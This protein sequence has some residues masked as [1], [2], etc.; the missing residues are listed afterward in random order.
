MKLSK[1]FLAAGVCAA[2][3]GALGFWVT[4]T[5]GA[6]WWMKQGPSPQARAFWER[7]HA[8]NSAWLDPRPPAIAYE[9]VLQKMEH[10]YQR[11]VDFWVDSGVLKTWCTPEKNLRL[12]EKQNQAGTLG[13]TIEHRYFHGRGE[14]VRLKSSGR[15]RELGLDVWL[16]GRTGGGFLC[17]TH[18]LA[19]WGLL[20]QAAVHER[21]ERTLVL[22]LTNLMHLPRDWR[23]DLMV[24]PGYGLHPAVFATVTGVIPGGM[25][26]AVDRATLLPLYV[27]ETDDK[28]KTESKITFETPWL[29][30][31]GRKVPGVIR[32]E[33]PRLKQELRYEFAVE[34][35][36][37]LL[38]ELVH[39]HAGAP[40]LNHRSYT[41]NL[42]I[43]PVPDAFFPSPADLEIP[44][45]SFTTLSPGE[46]MVTVRTADGLLLEGKLSLPP[47]AT[48]PAPVVFFL[49]GAGPWTFDRPLVYPDFE[50]AGEFMPRMKTRNYCDW[51]ARELSAR[52][53]GFFRM[54]KR[55]CGIVRDDEGHPREIC[56]RSVFSKA[57]PAVL[58][59]DFQAA[60]A[61]LRQ[62]AGVDSNRV[63]L[64]GA[65]EG[66]R[67]AAKLALAA[68]E[69][70]VA[71]AMFGYAEHS[72]KDIV[73]W[74]H[75]EG[76]W[77]NIARIFDADNDRKVT[78]QEYDEA[79]R[80]KGK[81]LAD[82]LPFAELD[83]NKNGVI[84]PAEM[85]Q[86]PRAEAVFK[87]VRE[88]DDDY[89]WDNLLNL[90]SAY[91]IEEWNSAPTHRTLLQI[92][93]P[94]AIFHGEDDGTCRV[95]GAREA[96][97]AFQKAGKNNLTLRTYP[98][99]DHDL[100][101]ARVLRDGQVPAPF[102]D[103]FDYI[104]RHARQ[105]SAPARQG[106]STT[107]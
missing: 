93:M 53:L 81:I 13:R 69:G 16:A 107:R 31:Q 62:E 41:R 98:K 102:V 101:W 32:C 9:I 70:I 80:R 63:I 8:T 45:H 60:L 94:L 95:E 15:L 1:R 19:V 84:T 50:Q 71:A 37:W 25:E 65:S 56:N 67:L 104:E 26:M 4:R 103:L 12:I 44:A 36:V 51:F 21:D 46:R 52:R 99:T 33:L 3:L 77:R 23:R 2:L 75:T 27:L 48:G 39:R 76:P 5:S 96:L 66:T 54:N 68:P 24:Y 49:P 100:N 57:T 55:G 42:Q 40:S 79:V 83:R 59:A 87:A 90:S 92:N 14:A 105:T 88:H 58:L 22:S 30:L 28:G 91:L 17:F 20:P 38:R 43:G 97:Q 11:Q 106:N 89:L 10:D 47:D 35:G 78:R 18:L 7:F 74:Q 6:R 73:R 85:D 29:T 61:V 64:L 72:L 86:S 82:S 34:Q